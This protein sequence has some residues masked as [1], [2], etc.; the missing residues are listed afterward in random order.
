VL[1]ERAEH[2]DRPEAGLEDA[3]RTLRAEPDELRRRLAVGEQI[4][5]P[6]KCGP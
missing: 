5:L 3:G 6:P 1:D 4:G 2:V